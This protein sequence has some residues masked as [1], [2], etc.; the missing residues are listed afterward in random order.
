M[1]EL[2][3][4][5]CV[6]LDKRRHQLLVYPNRHAHAV[7]LEL[8][9]AESVV[10][11]VCYDR[12]LTDRIYPFTASLS[13]HSACLGMLMYTYVHMTMRIAHTQDGGGSAWPHAHGGGLAVRRN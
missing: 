13:I 6:E 11:R 4:W 10:T 12:P 7:V 2:I 9:F 5:S 8:P 1:D 3:V